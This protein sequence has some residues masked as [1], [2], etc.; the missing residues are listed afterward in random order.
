MLGAQTRGYSNDDLAFE[1]IQHFDKQSA[2]RQIGAHRLLLL[3]GHGSHLTMEL[4]QYCEERNIHLLALPAHTSHFLQPL[5]V[6]LFQPYKHHH[7][8][9]VEMAVR[10]GCTNFNIVEFLHALHYIR[11]ATFKPMSI[12]SAWE[13]TG[14]IPYNPELILTKLRRQTAVVRPSTPPPT[15]PIVQP[16]LQPAP[17]RTPT[18]PRSVSQAIGEL[19]NHVYRQDA[20]HRGPLYKLMKGASINATL[21]AL[22]KEDLYKI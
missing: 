20:R 14:L 13:K 10:T 17:L 12:K 4:A 7:R 22:A 1:W 11:V 8:R 2:R 19:R 5:D 21:R 3:D 6:V 18:T 16:P 9:A 15:T